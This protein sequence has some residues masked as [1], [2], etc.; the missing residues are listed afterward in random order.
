VGKN[1]EWG[2][3]GAGVDV[4]GRREVVWGVSVFDCWGV[5]RGVSM[6]LV[7]G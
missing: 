6:I 4:R 2:G 7:V 5:G 3:G 1:G